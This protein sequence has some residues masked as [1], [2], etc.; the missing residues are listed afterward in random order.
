MRITLFLVVGLLGGALVLGAYAAH[1]LDTLELHSVDARF[2]LRGTQHP[3]NLVVVAIDSTTF[4][5]LGSQWP[6]PRRFDAKVINRIAAGHPKAIAY[7]IQFT[8][9][10]DVA[11]DNAL[12]QAVANAGHVVLATADVGP[13]GQTNIFGGGSVLHQIGA[14]AGNALL[15]ADADGVIRRAPYELSNLQSFGVVAA[16]VASGHAIAPPP[17]NEFWIDYAGPPG[18][19]KTVSFSSVMLGRVPSSLFHDKLV[20]VGPS[21]PTLQDVHA[22]SESGSSWMSGA[23]IQANIADTALRGFPL[24]GLSVYWGAGLILLFGL[25]APLASMRFS[26]RWTLALTLA[27]GVLFAVAV[28]VAFD[29]GRVVLFTYPLAAL[30]LS[31]VGA[32]VVRY[33]LEA[34]ER[35][36]THDAFSRF[37]PEA[38]VERVLARTHG[39]LR[40]GGE[41][42]TGT[43]MFTDLRGFTTFSESLPAEQVIEILNRYLSEMSDAILANGGTLVS[44]LGDGILAVFG[45]PLEQPDHASRALTTARELLQVRLPTVNEWLH[46]QGFERGFQMGIGLNTGPFMSGNVGSERRLEYTAIGDTINTASRIEGMTKGTPYSL[47]FAEETRLAL[48]DDVPDLVFFGESPVRGRSATIKLWSVRAAELAQPTGGSTGAADPK[49]VPALA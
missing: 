30:L 45:A 10:S 38:V 14:R 25:I 26:D 32:L 8:E 22:T 29:H 16:E 19:V 20:V 34:F 9:R 31:A 41:T 39:D 27:V 49:A 33:I 7:D 42:V 36:R 1:I 11:D 4:N 17:G 43:V 46:E 5:Q 35:Q 23:E 13:Q 48:G 24:R 37:V 2:A 12:I 40:L 44:Y 18:T 21:D 3:K 15:P 28:Q 47:L 6:F